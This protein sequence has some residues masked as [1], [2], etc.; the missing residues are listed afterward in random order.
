MPYTHPT[1]NVR[2]V[3]RHLTCAGF[4]L[5]EIADFEPPHHLRKKSS[6]FMPSPGVFAQAIFRHR[7]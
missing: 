3:I 2:Y 1:E 6:F 5:R 7:L 4:T